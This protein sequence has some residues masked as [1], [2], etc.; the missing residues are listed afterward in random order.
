ME[1]KGNLWQSQESQDTILIKIMGLLNVLMKKKQRKETPT[2]ENN[3]ENI[4]LWDF[5]FP[6]NKVSSSPVFY[7]WKRHVSRQK[8]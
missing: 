7:L 5:V 8:A 6:D 4:I 2:F 3:R 1:K